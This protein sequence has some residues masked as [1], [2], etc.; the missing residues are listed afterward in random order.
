MRIES[1]SW[2][3]ACALVVL[4]AVVLLAS[5]T[6]A[7]AQRRVALVIGNA[8]YVEPDA[9]LTNSVNDARTVAGV[10]AEL[11]FE[12]LL[13]PDLD[14]EG[15]ERAVNDFIG[16]LRSGDVALFYYAGHG[17][18][19]DDGLNYLAPVDFSSSY[20]E[21]SAKFRSLRADV[22]QSRM[23][24]AGART[25]IVI[26]DACRNNPFGERM[27]SLTRGGLE[28]LGADVAAG[29]SGG[30]FDRAG[31]HGYRQWTVYRSPAGGVAGSRSA[32]YG[33]LHAG[34]RSGRGGV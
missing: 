13:G 8:A 33:G 25:R 9:R 26:L 16:A 20:D 18:E 28:R 7:S 27:M 21:V 14:R 10:L 24:R 12:V 6:P 2:R 32:G 19:L 11:D 3:A 1:K 31:R 29:R 15:M 22:V 23:E 34:E 4:L 17:L 30:V 5:P